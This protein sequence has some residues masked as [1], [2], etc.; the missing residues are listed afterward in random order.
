MFLINSSS[1]SLYF[2]YISEALI[3]KR[4][5]RSML[6]L[7]T[8]L[9]HRSKEELH[10]DCLVLATAKHSRGTEIHFLG[11]SVVFWE[12]THKKCLFICYMNEPTN[13]QNCCISAS[14]LPHTLL[15]GSVHTLTAVSTLQ[16]LGDIMLCFSI[17]NQVVASHMGAGIGMMA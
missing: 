16:C 2:Y 11:P 10:Q 3:K 5:A 13:V 14:S 17:I 15:P 8:S 7:S 9:D 12:L 1:D 4:K 6:P